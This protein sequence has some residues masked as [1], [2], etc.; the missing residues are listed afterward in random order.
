MISKVIA[1]TT[2]LHLFESL[3]DAHLFL[4][5]KKISRTMIKV[6]RY[7]PIHNA[8][9]KQMIADNTGSSHSTLENCSSKAL[10]AKHTLVALLSLPTKL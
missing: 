10:L 2:M 3:A 5:S 6:T 4:C 1:T 7:V 8:L 9:A